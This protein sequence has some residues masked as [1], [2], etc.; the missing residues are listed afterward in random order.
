MNLTDQDIQEF[1]DI[2]IKEF[3]EDLGMDRA[4]YG[5]QQADGVCLA[6]MPLCGRCFFDVYGNVH[7][8]LWLDRAAG[9]VQ[10]GCGEVGDV[11]TE[12]MTLLIACISY[13]V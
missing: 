6:L 4:R 9:A 13:R 7:L 11:K 2:W 1:R 10:G 8:K 5:S 3:G 12:G